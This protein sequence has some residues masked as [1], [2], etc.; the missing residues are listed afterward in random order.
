MEVVAVFRM[1]IIEG[2]ME[3]D[4]ENDHNAM[5]VARDNI[6]QHLLS[7]RSRLESVFEH[8]YEK[9]NLA[10]YGFD[11]DAI[12]ELDAAPVEELFAEVVI[13]LDDD[14]V[15]DYM[16]HEKYITQKAAD[17]LLESGL[18]ATGH[19]AR[20]NEQHISFISLTNDD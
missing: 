18:F 16:H 14:Y 2:L 4:V 10:D 17:K 8:G 20:V 15:N 1:P 11:E 9:D 19:H 13:D 5:V 3:L 7:G 12:E 6:V